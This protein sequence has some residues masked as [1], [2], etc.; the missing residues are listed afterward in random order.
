M[1]P[2]SKR[3]VS[4]GFTLIELLVVI[5]IIAII[6]AILFPVFA[7]AREK[8]RQTTCTSNLRQLGMAFLQYTQDYD[9]TLPG[10]YNGDYG[11]DVNKTHIGG[12]IY[13]SQ[14]VEDDPTA[15]DFDPTLG[16]IYPY[17]KS[18][19]VYVCPDD[20]E[21]MITGDSYAVNSC[22]DHPS[23]PT[24]MLATGKPLAAIATPSGTML[25]S[26][27]AET[28]TGDSTN[29]GYLNLNF[30]GEGDSL[31]SR[32]HNGVEVSFVDGHVKWYP[33]DAVH[34]AG[35]QTGVPGEVAGVTVC[36]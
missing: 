20:S 11:I 4:R 2:A 19:Q 6:A 32:H 26:E 33:T 16:T 15:K 30:G 24:T 27:E 13:Y 14:F 7:Q 5:A 17:V 31:A 23:D 29:D 18:T 8:A 3:A 22:V 1:Q 28:D 21:G 9:E 10:S 12:W 35:L 34:P 36:P 25:L